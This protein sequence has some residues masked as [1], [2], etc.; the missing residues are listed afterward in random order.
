MGEKACKCI[1]RKDF[2]GLRFKVGSMEG[3]RGLLK[4]GSG[5]PEGHQRARSAERGARLKQKLF[6]RV[7]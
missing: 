1:G 5:I 3:R 6:G 4:G 2:V 7:L